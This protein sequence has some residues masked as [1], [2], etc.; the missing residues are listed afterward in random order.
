MDFMWMLHS[1]GH[2]GVMAAVSFTASGVY[3]VFLDSSSV[4]C[5]SGKGFPR[6]SDHRKDD[7]PAKLEQ[8]LHRWHHI[9]VVLRIHLVDDQRKKF[10]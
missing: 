10:I 2:T 1:W 7:P 5:P 9:S 8:A 6:Y 3:I 4:L